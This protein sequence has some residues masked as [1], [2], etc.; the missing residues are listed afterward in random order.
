[1]TRLTLRQRCLRMLFVL[2]GVVFCGPGSPP[3]SCCGGEELPP[4]V[5]ADLSQDAAGLG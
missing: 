1:M 3:L 5:Q 2:T 4:D